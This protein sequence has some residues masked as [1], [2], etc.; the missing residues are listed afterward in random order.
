M[1]FTSEDLVKTGKYF[2]VASGYVPNQF[3]VKITKEG[4]SDQESGRGGNPLYLLNLEPWIIEEVSL[5]QIRFNTG[6]DIYMDPDTLIKPDYILSVET[7]GK[8]ELV[9]REKSDLAIH[10]SLIR[11]QNGFYNPSYEGSGSLGEEYSIE[12]R[13]KSQ[14]FDGNASNGD[15]IFGDN[16]LVFGRAILRDISVPRH[17]YGEKEFLTYTVTFDVNC[18][19]ET[20]QLNPKQ[21]MKSLFS[22]DQ[23][24]KIVSNV[25]RIV[26]KK[27][28]NYIEDK[29][30]PLQIVTGEKAERARRQYQQYNEARARENATINPLNIDLNK[31]SSQVDNTGTYNLT[32]EQ[33]NK[34]YNSISNAL[35]PGQLTR[36]GKVINANDLFTSH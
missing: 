20:Y 33:T 30:E 31:I 11:C 32:E 3:T 19:A 5:P 21:K 4:V 2:K 22:T 26:K 7:M 25:G 16:V 36:N 28:I 23:N 29:L 8:L 12:V 14:R 15:N 27:E 18:M 17:S 6:N 10:R 1:S 9:L 34:L 13:M 35:V 24:K